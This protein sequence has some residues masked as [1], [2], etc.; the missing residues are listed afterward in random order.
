M[1]MAIINLKDDKTTLNYFIE[2]KEKIFLEEKEIHFADCDSREL[3]PRQKES[4][5]F[6]ETRNDTHRNLSPQ[7]LHDPNYYG[8]ING[9]M[10]PV[11]VYGFGHCRP[12]FDPKIE[13]DYYRNCEYKI[14]KGIFLYKC[15][16][17]ERS[18]DFLPR[19]RDAQDQPFTTIGHIEQWVPWV[20]RNATPITVSRDSKYYT[21]IPLSEVNR[22]FNDTT[23]FELQESTLNSRLAYPYKDDSQLS[24]I[25]VS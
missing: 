23:N 14:D 16:T 20:L 8:V 21:A 24:P 12:N 5:H 19:R 1:G 7:I 6:M 4:S 10:V 3:R 11:K 22:C 25:L 2:L 9:N 17:D 15:R 18:F 13:D